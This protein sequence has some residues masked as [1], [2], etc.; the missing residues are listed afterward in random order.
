[1]KGTR[2]NIQN[3]EKRRKKKITK[4]NMQKIKGKKKN[5]KKLFWIF[6]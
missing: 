4:I 3:K 2:A 5:I 1:M 6:F